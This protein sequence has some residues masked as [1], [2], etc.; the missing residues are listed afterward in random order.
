MTLIRG[1]SEKQEESGGVVGW[2]VQGQLEH[3]VYDANISCVQWFLLSLG[4][5]LM[6]MTGPFAIL[7]KSEGCSFGI[8]A[9]ISF[10][11]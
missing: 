7:T 8:V 11:L 6:H 5:T 9:P 2:A 10:S 3:I 4:K 1:P